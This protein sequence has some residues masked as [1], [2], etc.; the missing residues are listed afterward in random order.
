[1]IKAFVDTNVLISAA[2]K[3][4]GHSRELIFRAVKG[5]FRPYVTNRNLISARLKLEE[6]APRTVNTFDQL[7]ADLAPAIVKDPIE[8]EVL[9]YL[10]KVRK[11]S[12]AYI[13]TAATK[14]NCEYVVTWNVRDFIKEN[15]EMIK[16]VTPAEFIGVLNSAL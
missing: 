4:T 8:E 5:D 1:M 10:D 14:A 16:V 9:R 3:S 13:V 7:V 6:I 11:P 2:Y 12:D 15:L